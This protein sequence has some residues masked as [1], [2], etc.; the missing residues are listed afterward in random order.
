M[1]SDDPHTSAALQALCDSGSKKQKP[2]VFWIGAGASAW[3]GF[4][5]WD[6][7]TANLHS[8]FGRTIP[9]YEKQSAGHALT[10]QKFPT[11][12]QLMKDADPPSYFR[13]LTAAFGPSSHSPVYLRLLRSLKKIHPL[14]ILTTNVDETLERNLDSTV[15]VQVSDVER[16]GG[17]VQSKQ[18]F[19]CK[20]HGT[21]SAAQSMVFTDDD[22][23]R[24]IGKA[25]YLAT[26]RELFSLSTV[27]F[28]GYSLRDE[29]LVKLLLES[30]SNHPLFGTGPHFLI[31]ANERTDSGRRKRAVLKMV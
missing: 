17:L 14:H 10:E 3:A 29:Y 19:I 11:V 8:H 28:V 2:I 12:F 20:L 27:V 21:S 5:L 26:I 4:P 25:S 23:S 31:T 16:I 30:E 9:A 15:T 7:L 13:E 6:E 1:F 22:Y 24:L 18:S